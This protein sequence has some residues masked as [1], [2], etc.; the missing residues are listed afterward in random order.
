ME[1]EVYLRCLCVLRRVCMALVILLLLLGLSTPV[2]AEE[3]AILPDQTEGQEPEGGVTEE[4]FAAVA[5]QLEAVAKA[6]GRAIADK[7]L[8][9]SFRVILPDTPA[10]EAETSA[11]AA[12]AAVPA[13]NTP[14]VV[15]HTEREAT[16]SF[17]G[18]LPFLV[19]AA[20]AGVS[21][22]FVLSSLRRRGRQTAA[23]RGY[24]PVQDM[25]FRDETLEKRSTLRLER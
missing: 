8:F 10:P 23:A 17:S 21:M 1:R 18:V 24:R 5:A 25:T 15:V 3:S 9:E 7:M 2:L 14:A 20:V 12:P 16:W 6:E 13:Q 4:D 22:L 11:W 19:V